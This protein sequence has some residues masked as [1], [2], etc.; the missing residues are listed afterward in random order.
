MLLHSKHQLLALLAC[1]A[2][3][4]LPGVPVPPYELPKELLVVGAAEL[5]SYVDGRPLRIASMNLGARAKDHQNDRLLAPAEERGWEFKRDAP[6]KPEGL[7]STTVGSTLD[8]LL[9]FDETRDSAKYGRLQV[10]LL[11]SYAH[12][13]LLRVQLLRIPQAK[14]GPHAPRA[15]NDAD[16]VQL[17]YLPVPQAQLAECKAAAA[18]AVEIAAAD[19]DCLWTDHSSEPVTDAINFPTADLVDSCLLIRLSVAPTQRAETKIKLFQLV[20]Y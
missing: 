11:K 19:V 13:G 5:A 2:A 18:N 10:T 20:V 4:M 8:V 12:M 7:I 17:L 6:T 1:V 15:A 9:T 14:D 16:S 3:P